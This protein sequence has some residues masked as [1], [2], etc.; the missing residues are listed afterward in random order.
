[1]ALLEVGPSAPELPEVHVKY[2]DNPGIT[3]RN[4][5]IDIVS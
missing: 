1:M 2:A 4:R 5:F 3:A